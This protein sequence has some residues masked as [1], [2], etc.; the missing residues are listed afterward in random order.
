MEDEI[1]P[2]NWVFFAS[3]QDA[4]QVYRFP[5]D[6]DMQATLQDF[7]LKVVMGGERP[8]EVKFDVRDAGRKRKLKRGRILVLIAERGRLM[9]C[10]PRN[11]L[12]K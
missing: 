6:R 2:G 12:L 1:A 3:Q 5:Y 7:K 4:P 8:I 11:F 9:T 10:H